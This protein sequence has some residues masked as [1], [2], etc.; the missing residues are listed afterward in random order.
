MFDHAAALVA[1]VKL[2]GVAQSKG[3]FPQRDKFLL[4]AG[5]AGARAGFRTVSARC[6][7]LVLAHNP[8][9]LI[10]GHVTLE[11]ALDNADFQPFL[12]Q[13]QRFCSYEL[14]EHHLT[15]LAIA[16]GLPTRPGTVAAADYALL[17]LSKADLQPG[18]ADSV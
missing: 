14:A 16:P 13:L 17:L 2:A 3:Q 11:E 6:R 18:P 10:K 9:H 15:Q 7:D 5:I 8:H 12:V 4:L 1:F